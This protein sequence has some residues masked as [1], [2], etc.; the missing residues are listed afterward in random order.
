MGRSVTHQGEVSDQLADLIGQR[1]W[2][3]ESLAGVPDPA[4][5]DRRAQRIA[6]AVAASLCS[7]DDNTAAQ[8]TIDVGN[9]LWPD[10]D[11]P[12]DWWTTP[13]GRACA[14]SLGTDDQAISA[15][16]AAAMLGT[17]RSRVYQLVDVGRLDRHPDGGVVRSSV[18]RRLAGG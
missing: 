16:N 11:P 3:I 2:T 12:D 4:D 17:S 15:S 10:H 5:L 14:R 1:L 18:M 6:S 7:A 8:A 13:L 9:A